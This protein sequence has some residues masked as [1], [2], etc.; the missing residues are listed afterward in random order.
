MCEWQRATR[1]PTKTHS[2]ACESLANRLE[3]FDVDAGCGL[4]CT[5]CTQLRTRVCCVMLAE[6]REACALCAASR[7]AGE[8][9]RVVHVHCVDHQ[10]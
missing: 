4:F 2:F 5:T 10:H 3:F 9:C 6:V 7:P 8:S 1:W